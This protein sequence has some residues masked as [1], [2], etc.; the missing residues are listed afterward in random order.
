[1]DL[2][3]SPSGSGL[4][5][6]VRKGRDCGSSEIDPKGISRL[7]CVGVSLF[8]RPAAIMEP[9]RPGR[10]VGV[11]SDSGWRRERAGLRLTGRTGR[12]ADSSD[13]CSRDLVTLCCDSSRLCRTGRFALQ[14]TGRPS[15]R[16]PGMLCRRLGWIRFEHVWAPKVNGIVH[17]RACALYCSVMARVRVLAWGAEGWPGCRVM[18]S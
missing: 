2:P 11:A 3:R 5:L 1:M 17:G 10:G 9:V 12:V 8:P 7:S 6:S 18:C 14:G 13:G 16:M 15:L 4:S